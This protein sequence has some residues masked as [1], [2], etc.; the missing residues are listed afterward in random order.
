MN[1]SRQQPAFKGS[2]RAGLRLVVLSVVLLGTTSVM[3]ALFLRFILGFDFHFQ[4]RGSIAIICI[5]LLAILGIGFWANNR[6][7]SRE[8]P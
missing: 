1:E 5:L 7:L 2:F 3:A 6:K 8:A 4:V